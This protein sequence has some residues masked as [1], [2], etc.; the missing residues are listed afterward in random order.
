M[1]VERADFGLDAA[2]PAEDDGEADGAD[3]GG[4]VVPLL[5]AAELDVVVLTAAGVVPS[6]VEWASPRLVHVH[7]ASSALS[8]EDAA[9]ASSVAAVSVMT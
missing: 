7:D 6:A 2:E 9:A 1:A 3:V 5:G 8:V 4:E